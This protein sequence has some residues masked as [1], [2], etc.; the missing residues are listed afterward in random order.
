MAAIVSASG[1][2]NSL[3]GFR[4]LSAAAGSQWHTAI[5]ASFSSG[6]PGAANRLKY[7]VSSSGASAVNSRKKS[8]TAPARLTGWAT[9]PP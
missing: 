8:R 9:T 1:G 4:S 5:T 6:W 2:P 7:A 3:S